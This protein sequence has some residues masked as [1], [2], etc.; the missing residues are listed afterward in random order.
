M[1][2]WTIPQVID[3]ALDVGKEN[4][5]YTVASVGDKSAH[6][7]TVTVMENGMTA[8]ITG[9]TVVVYAM[10]PDG[11]RVL[12]KG[13]VAGNMAFAYLPQECYALTGTVLAILRVSDGT[14]TV[15]LARATIAVEPNPECEVID[16]GQVIP[17]LDDL[18]VMGNNVQRALEEALAATTDARKA[19]A[20]A[21]VASASATQ[22]A[23]AIDGMT[24]S[25]RS[26]PP[27]APPTAVISTL[28][29]AKHIAFGIPE[30][31]PGVVTELGPGLFA[32]H[33][34][35]NGHLILTHGDHEDPPP[36][37]IQ[38]GRLIYTIA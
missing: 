25:A 32:F 23:K 14:R 34:D 6:A 11:K 1:S 20:A 17:N 31:R 33:I 18:I 28:N 2:E 19:A 16:P 3:L 37:S 38:G 5:T 4:R 29:E 21:W 35:Y 7:W 10:R 12:V 30:G 24:V 22:A 27:G 15:T 9:Y 13:G 36:L 8:N 26:V